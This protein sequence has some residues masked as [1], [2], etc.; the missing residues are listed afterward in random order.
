M[1][2]IHSTA[3]IDPTAEV[4]VGTTIGPYTV[5]GPHVKIGEN[6]KIGSHVVIE[7]HT[8][9]GNSNTIFQFASVGAAPQ[10]LKY[11]GEES[12]LILG[13]E[14][15]IREYV[16]LQPGTEGGGMETRIGDKNLFMV[17][18]H[19]GH[20]TIIGD[21]N[22]FANSVALSGHVTIGSMVTLGG[23]TGVHQFCHMGDFSF[24]GAGAMV[25]QDIPP[26]CMAQGDRAELVGLNQVGLKRNGF[27]AEDVKKLRSLFRELF[28]GDGTLKE[29]IQSLQQKYSHFPKGLEFVQFVSKSDR[30]VASPRK[31]GFSEKVED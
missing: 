31:K 12:R 8:T 17:C 11:R 10:D 1:S 9:V 28:W 22:I 27:S 3:I 6:N 13:S 26:Y 25:A 2:S 16:T 30:G 20:D 7:G 23:M 14:N 29:R 21:R 19:V 15:I 5:V 24:T 4:G 18:S